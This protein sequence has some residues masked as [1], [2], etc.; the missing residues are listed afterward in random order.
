[1]RTLLRLY[2]EKRFSVKSATGTTHKTKN[3]QNFQ[4]CGLVMEKSNEHR[5]KETIEKKETQK[6]ENIWIILESKETF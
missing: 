4:N 6:I 1:M 2:K 3:V 5:N